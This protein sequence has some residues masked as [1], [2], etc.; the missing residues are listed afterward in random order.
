MALF[1]LPK[2][3]PLNSGGV[4]MAGAKLYFYRTGT[5]TPQSIY[6]DI[7]LS[8]AHSNP[9][10]ADANGT[11]A[12]IYL[13]TRVAFNYRVTLTT[14]ADVTVS[15]YPIDDYP[16]SPTDALT[17]L[18]AGSNIFTGT[19][20]EL[21][22]AEPRLLF[23]ETDAGSNLKLW[24][25]DVNAGVWSWRTRT[26]AD[27]A[28]K[29]IIVATRGSTTAIASLVY[30]NSTDLP[31]HQFQGD[32]SATDAG[33][34]LQTVGW[35]DV[36]Q[37]VQDATYGFVLSDR[38]KSVVHTS[39]STH[40]WTI[41]ANASV[42]FPVGSAITVSNGPS[43]GNVTI[44]IT[45]DTLRLAGSGTTGSRTLT[46]HGLATLYKYSSTVWYVA[47]TNIT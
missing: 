23:Y 14:S 35:R 26:D 8:V 10:I 6:T 42:A 25:V 13:D 30:G 16:A 28:G 9:V 29:N 37:N 2:A 17:A 5:S 20:N 15:G 24:D 44:A 19:F 21:Q 11:F 4:L 36:P 39:G 1:Y 32:L 31:T 18:L 43:G 22:S 12:P 40:T 38:G 46:A 47:G 27:G 41:P 34:T 45:T 3:V 7:A 33:G